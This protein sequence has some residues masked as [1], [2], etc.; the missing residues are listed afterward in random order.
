MSKSPL[1]LAFFGGGLSS[2]VG[3]VHRTASQLDG[4]WVV[5]GGCFSRDV[6]RS[7]ATAEAWGVPRG[8]VCTDLDDVVQRVKRGEFDAVAVLTPTPEHIFALEGLLDARVPI[9]CEKALTSSDSESGRV[10]ELQ[11]STR[12]FL[13]TT[14]NYTGYPMVR[15]LRERIRRGD[16]GR[17]HRIDVRMPQETFLPPRHSGTGAVQDWRRRDYGLPTISLDLGVHVVEMTRFL[18][19]SP[20]VEVTA[21]ADSFGDLEVTDEVQALVRFG[22][23]AIGSLWFSKAALGNRNG[24]AVEIFGDEASAAWVQETPDSFVLRRRDRTVQVIDRGSPDLVE[25]G[26]P[27]YVRFKAGHPTG[28]IEAFANLYM[29][30]ADALASTSGS[31]E[32]HRVRNEFVADASATHYGMMVLAAMGRSSREHRWISVDPVGPGVRG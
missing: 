4:R 6:G 11:R 18:S 9:V 32:G 7:L 3:Y 26:K 22:D 10:I 8:G 29:D 25:A 31:E 5:A 23:G 28:F 27:R 12:T 20:I 21:T 1:R 16:L 13:A 19:S 30:I 15:E 14:L 2:A 24:L 17:I